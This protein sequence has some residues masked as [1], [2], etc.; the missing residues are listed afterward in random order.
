MVTTILPVQSSAPCSPWRNWL[1]RQLNASSW[2]CSHSFSPQLFTGEPSTWA[3]RS[4][5]NVTAPD[6]SRATFSGS[7][8]IDQSRSVEPFHCDD[9]AFS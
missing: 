2:N 3:M 4:W 6:I 8:S 9:F 7:T 5:K 1:I